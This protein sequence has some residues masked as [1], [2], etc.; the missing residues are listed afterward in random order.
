MACFSLRNAR[1]T[2]ALLAVLLTGGCGGARYQPEPP[3]RAATPPP[4]PASEGGGYYLDD[5]PL[6]YS[7][8]QL[9]AIPDARPR[10]EKIRAANSRP[11]VVLGNRYVPFTEPRPYRARGQA[12]WYG[13]RY[14]GKLTASGEKYDMFKMTAAH[15]V[16]PIPSY[17][18]VSRPDGRSVVVRINDRGP[19]LHG[20]LIDL[21]FVAA[22]RLGIVQDGVANVLV[23]AILFDG[24]AQADAPPPSNAAGSGSPAGGG[25]VFYVQLGA[26]SSQANAEALRR[27][28]AL[29][30]AGF[31]HQVAVSGGKYVVLAG[32]YVLESH[33][34][35]GARTLCRLDKRW[36]GFV[37]RAHW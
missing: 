30:A 16:L 25:D 34:N 29:S 1:A 20:R 12:S 11:Y 27:D 5:G 28:F 4:A 18:R 31:A 9:A 32:P 23:E 14:H 24:D 10:P 3:S 36:C 22:H 13:K 17:V 21:S 26:F 6:A 8:E 35:A 15:P 33:A 2:A 7:P 19:F 37:I